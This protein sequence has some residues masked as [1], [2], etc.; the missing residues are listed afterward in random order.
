MQEKYRYDSATGNLYEYSHFHNCYLFVCSNP[1]RLSEQE[2][3]EE[4]EERNES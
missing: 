4:Y 3:I 2:L 1:F